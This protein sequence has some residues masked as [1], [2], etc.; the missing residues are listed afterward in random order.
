MSTSR[1]PRLRRRGLLGVPAL[2]AAAL[3]VAVRP[4][5]AHAAPKAECLADLLGEQ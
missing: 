1:S 2:V 4:G 5:T 3:A